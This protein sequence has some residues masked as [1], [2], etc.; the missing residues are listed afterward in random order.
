VALKNH[1]HFLNYLIMLVFMVIFYLYG[2][3]AVYRDGCGLPTTPT[4]HFVDRAFAF[5]SCSPWVASTA[6][7][8]GTSIFWVGT[9]AACQAYQMFYLGMT[10]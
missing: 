10:T 9:L 7:L 5:G 6:T 8:G 1:K 3:F 2:C 4:E